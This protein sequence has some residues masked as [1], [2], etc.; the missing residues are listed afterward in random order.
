MGEITLAQEMA[1][2]PDECKVFAVCVERCLSAEET[3]W[4]M[5]EWRTIRARIESRK[6][7]G[8]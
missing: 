3:Q 7:G 1:H 4:V 5:D 2:E 6:G 8:V